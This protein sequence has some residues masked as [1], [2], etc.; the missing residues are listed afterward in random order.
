[1]A[2]KWSGLLALVPLLVLGLVWESGA[3]KT[4]GIREPFPWRTAVGLAAALAGFAL[5]PFPGLV[6]LWVAV[7]VLAGALAWEAAARRTAQQPGA[8]LVPGLLRHG[9]PWVVAL[10]VLP[11][12]VYL[13][14]WA[15]WF[16]TDG[17]YDR[18]WAQGRG[19]SL[20]YLPDFLG[21]LVPDALRSWWHYHY[22]MWHF[23]DTLTAKHPYQSHPLSWP[24]LGR[25]VSYYYPPGIGLGRYGCTAQSCSRE[26]LAIGTP[27]I[28][29]A[30]VPATLLLV[31]RWVAR[32]DWRA[33]A[34]ALMIAVPVLA[35][36]PSDLKGRTMFIF[37]ALPAIPF[38][39]L[40]LALIAGWVLRSRHR[41]TGGIGVGVYLGLVVANFAYLYPVLAAVTLPYS[42]WYDRMWFR[43]WI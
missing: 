31:A 26:V 17:G 39:C 43:S 3:R 12:A 4:A 36:I 18:Q 19:T 29:W 41:L 13:L 5:L 20:P 23:H 33:G 2:T 38:L 25:P 14:S 7:A 16:W 6:R 9:A 40:G 21:A 28:W 11:A 34:L 27:A 15:G 22:D 42:D 30:M 24:F 32:R 35:W 1:V 10:V 8:T 37:Y